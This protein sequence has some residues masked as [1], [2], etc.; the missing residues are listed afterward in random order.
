MPSQ[1]G[2]SNMGQIWVKYGSNMEGQQNAIFR[3]N[4]GLIMR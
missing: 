4:Y 2:E 1:K 3:K